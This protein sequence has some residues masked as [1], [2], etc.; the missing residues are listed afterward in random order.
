M[1]RNKEM[2]FQTHNTLQKHVEVLKNVQRICLVFL[3]DHKSDWKGVEKHHTG[4]EDCVTLWM[5]S[6]I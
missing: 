1:Q 3:G 4:Q 5:V 2:Y 6:C